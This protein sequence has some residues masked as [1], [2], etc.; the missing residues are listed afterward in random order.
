MKKCEASDDA[1]SFGG[2]RCDDGGAGSGVRSAR[3]R[4]GRRRFRIRNFRVLKPNKAAL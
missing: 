3:S 4:H 2:L 1:G